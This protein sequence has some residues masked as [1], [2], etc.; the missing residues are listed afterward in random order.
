MNTNQDQ[1]KKCYNER[2][3]KI[4]YCLKTMQLF[5]KNV[6]KHLQKLIHRISE[7]ICYLKY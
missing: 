5:F 7:Q 2:P 4:I 6:F 3:N 1:N